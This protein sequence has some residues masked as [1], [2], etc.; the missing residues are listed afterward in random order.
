[1]YRHSIDTIMWQARH[2]TSGCIPFVFNIPII[3]SC[4]SFCAFFLFSQIVRYTKLS[5]CIISNL[6]ISYSLSLD[7]NKTPPQSYNISSTLFY[8]YCLKSKGFFPSL[9]CTSSNRNSASIGF[10]R[11]TVSES[12]TSKFNRNCKIP[13]C[14][15]SPLRLLY[16]K[17]FILSIHVNKTSWFHPLALEPTAQQLI[18]RRP[19][20]FT[21]SEEGACCLIITADGLWPVC[22]HRWCP[23]TVWRSS[24]WGWRCVKSLQNR[25]VYSSTQGYALSLFNL[26]G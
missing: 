9:P 4:L 17:T 8:V 2:C 18:S 19:S 7:Q 16:S 6:W 13:I 26:L 5:N 1:M 24:S 21:S 23:G 25:Q 22:L 14:S 10:S 20:P 11:E 12:S 3:L 15:P